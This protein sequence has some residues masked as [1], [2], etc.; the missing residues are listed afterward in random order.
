M[1]ISDLKKT[2]DGKQGL[3]VNL[4][5]RLFK[6]LALNLIEQ[7]IFID[8]GFQFIIKIKIIKKNSIHF[9]PANFLFG[10]DC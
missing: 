7:L 1:F 6:K 10:I 9:L 3:T 4:I 2:A 8:S 5:K